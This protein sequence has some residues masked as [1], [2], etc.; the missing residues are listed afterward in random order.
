MAVWIITGTSSGFGTEF[1]KQA[2]GRGDKVI[3]TARTLSKIAHLKEVGAVT[4]SLDVTASQEE[5]NRKA[6][7]AISIYGQ[8]DVL[9]NNAAYTQFGTLED[10]G[11]DYAKQFDT[12]VFGTINIIRAFLPHLREKKAG[13]IVNI[14]SMA[15]WTTYPTVGA[16][17][18]SKAA[19]RYVTDAL[20]Q[21]V[22]GL[23]I[24]TLLVEPGY[25][26]TE[27]LSPQN[28]MFVETSISDYK[29][30]TEAAFGGFRAAHGNQV[31]D[32]V[33]G[34]SRVIDVVKGENGA[35]GKEWPK[36]LVLGSDSVETIRQKC[37]NTLK[38]L[39]EW[40]EFSCGTDL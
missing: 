25:F 40:E 6:I 7:E 31:G 19:I 15:A 33:K 36:E 4:L 18:A 1:V 12:N 35:A 21:E 24:K 34:V 23:G 39:E 3:A 27:L 5:L 16:Y 37:Q 2:L 32:P 22:S 28:S 17:S 13:T 38:L 8:I 26:R 29:A 11:D 20:D 10:L 14:G 9:V 30:L